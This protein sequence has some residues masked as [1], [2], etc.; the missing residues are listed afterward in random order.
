MTWRLMRSYG[1]ITTLFE[2]LWQSEATAFQGLCRYYYKTGAC[3]CQPR[4]RRKILPVL[5]LKTFKKVG[6]MSYEAD[7]S[8]LEYPIE[9]ERI[10]YYGWRMVQVGL[11]CYIT[12]G[13]AS[14]YFTGHIYKK[15]LDSYQCNQKAPMRHP[16]EMHAM[17]G[18]GLSEAYFYVS[19]GE[20]DSSNKVEKYDIFL[21]SWD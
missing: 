10:S 15:D 7:R 16:R 3:R 11:Q 2:F 14:K 4:I 21:N 17:C 5:F 12:G 8:V 9:G 6:L 20:D 19:G 18:D 13:M 1:G